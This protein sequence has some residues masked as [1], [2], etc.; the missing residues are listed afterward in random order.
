MSANPDDR[1]VFDRVMARFP[2][3]FRDSRKDFGTDVFLR[4]FSAT[5]SKIFSR[6]KFFINDRVN[7]LV[8]LPDSKTPLRLDGDV[9]WAKTKNPGSWE[10]GIKF[11]NPQLMGMNRLFKFCV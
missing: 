6:E 7:L 8:E 10:I 2:V 9:V 3:K 11:D 5:G 1:R 4:D